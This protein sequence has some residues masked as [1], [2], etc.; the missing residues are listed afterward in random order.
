M[1]SH[2]GQAWLATS[3]R[4]IAAHDADGLD[5]LLRA[6]GGMGSFNDLV[7]M[8]INGHYIQQAQEA[9]VY[10]RLTHLRTAFGRG[11]H[12]AARDPPGPRVTRDGHPLR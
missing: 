2:T 8:N 7:V 6:C 12:L 5:C 11:D 10:R 1:A 3:K 9:T 4:E